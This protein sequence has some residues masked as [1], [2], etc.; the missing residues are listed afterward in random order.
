MTYVYIPYAR[1]SIVIA[2]TRRKKKGKTQCA[3]AAVH[4]IMTG[5]D[6]PIIERVFIVVVMY[7]NN[8][9]IIFM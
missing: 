2:P 3:A 8:I 4:N 6:C 7:N 9:I 1:R 5:P